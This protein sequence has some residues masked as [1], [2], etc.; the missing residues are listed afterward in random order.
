MKKYI[1]QGG[2]RPKAFVLVSWLGW[3]FSDPTFTGIN[4]G[5]QKARS[6]SPKAPPLE[7]LTEPEVKLSLHPALIIQPYIY[8]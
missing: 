7:A 5:L 8:Q 3:R 1:S 4:S 6:S 2:H